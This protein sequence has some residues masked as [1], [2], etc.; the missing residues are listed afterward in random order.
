MKQLLAFCE[1]SLDWVLE[2]IEALVTRESPT[3]DKAA[4][5]RCGAE[6]ARRLEAAGA[7]V[8][9]VAREAAGDAIVGEFG[10]RGAHILLLGHLDTVWPVGELTRRPLRT[11]GF[12][13][14]GPGVFDMK[15]GIAIGLLA[16]RA[17]AAVMPARLPRIT[18]LLTGDEESGST[19][20]RGLVEE[21]ARGSD[22]V[23]VLEPPLPGGALKTSR[24]GCGEFRLTVRGIAAHAGIEP[25]KGA[26]AVLELAEQLLA[27]ERLQDLSSG[28]TAT[29]GVISGG[30]RPNVVPAAA[31]A[32]ID[33]R[34]ASAAEAARLTGDLLS[35]RPRRSGTS[36]EIT[37]G[38]DHPPLERNA[39]VVRLFHEARTVAAE[40]GWDLQEGST[41][42]ASDG[43][44]AA[45]LGVPTL[46][47]LGSEGEG[48]HAEHEYVRVDRLAPRAALLAGLLARIG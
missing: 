17:V 20:S 35:L 4:V 12:H 28:T 13:L 27:V 47:G 14:H 2:V 42:G 43:N 16:V 33:V 11:D 48:A 40:L 23:L 7:R 45:A 6:A 38:F 9:R 19:A 44:F 46:D 30:I 26:N 41:G 15:G 18:F 21:Q 8:R 31:E 34:A 5:D 22:A 3:S 25:E 10:D 36:V 37:G 1:S 32:R 24:K 29:A 39:G